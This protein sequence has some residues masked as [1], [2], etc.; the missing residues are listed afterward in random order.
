MIAS[1]IARYFNW[2]K[3]TFFFLLWLWITLTAL[4]VAASEHLSMVI[5]INTIKTE[6]ACEPASPGR[7]TP[8][9]VSCEDRS[10]FLF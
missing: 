3:G 10:H 2:F 8:E 5:N 7:V 1:L 9:R 4:I 6:S